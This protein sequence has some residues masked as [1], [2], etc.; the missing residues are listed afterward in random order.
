MPAQTDEHG[1]GVTPEQVIDL[2]AAVTGVDEI[3]LNASLPKVG[4]VDEL[5]V[6]S[7]W[8]AVVEEHGERGLSD[9][10]FTEVREARTV[11]ELAGVIVR[12]LRGYVGLGDTPE[13]ALRSHGLDDA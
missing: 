5:D 10:D 1:E 7:F 6:L 2:L 12:H 13:R 8:D 4:L 3:D 11:V 9:P